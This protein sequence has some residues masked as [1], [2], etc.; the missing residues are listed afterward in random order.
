MQEHLQVVGRSYQKR[1][2]AIR[3]RIDYL[4]AQLKH[5]EA[6][7]EFL[8]NKYRTELEEFTQ[9]A[10]ENKAVTIQRAA[11]EKKKL[12]NQY[13]AFR[14][15][16]KVMDAE[17]YAIK[18]KQTAVNHD[19]NR[20]VNQNQVYRVATYISDKE[21]AMEVSHSLVGLVAL[22]WFASLAFISSVTGVFLAIAGI[23][24][25]KCYDPELGT[26]MATS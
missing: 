19:M 10:S 2:D 12:Y 1:I 14:A 17:I 23:Y 11:N 20:L 7:H 6:S 16:V 13:E 9:H 25:Q 15:K 26:D 4:N 21:D 5:Q 18:Q 24:I 8:Q 22:I 3:S